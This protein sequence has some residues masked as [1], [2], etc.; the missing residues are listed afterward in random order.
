MKKIKLL[1]ALCVC[2]ILL[3]SQAGKKTTVITFGQSAFLSE[4]SLQL[5]GEL[6]RD[7]I[8]ARFKRINQAGGINGKVLK[9]ESVDDLG[10]ADRSYTNI[11]MFR[12]KKID[13]FLGFTGT[14]GV[15]KALPLIKKKEIA[16]LFPWGGDDRLRQPNLTHLVSGLGLM[17]PQIDA[18]VEHVVYG[19]RINKVAIFHDD[20]G[21]GIANKNM[22][23]EKLA[24]EDIEPVAVASYNRFTLN[25]KA[26]AEELIKADPKIVICL[27]T[28]M[29]TA[30]M[31]N[32]FLANGHYGTKF[33]GIDSTMF[34]GNILKQKG[35]HF[36][37]TSPMPHPEDSDLEI[38]KEFREDMEKSSPE[39]PLNIL[40]LSYYIHAAIVEHA[41]KKIP[42]TVTKE[43]V[44][45]EIQ[46]MKNYNL[47]GFIVNFD[48]Q[49]RHAYPHN[50]SII[51]G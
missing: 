2:T 5:Y 26:A 19:M 27:A 12:K 23:I 31:I 50:I 34:V 7:A 3:C 35:V 43:G 13:M 33:I 29:P 4:G 36:E 6:I 30:K 38:V 8:N 47:G 32:Q 24:E 1:C 37:Y 9:L 16:M 46:N 44:L 14:R 40:S 15:L 22:T 42:G 25:V 11:E 39:D 41:I 20:G 18:I 48:P 51:K 21:F 28:S 45:Q 10:E 49:T 17:E